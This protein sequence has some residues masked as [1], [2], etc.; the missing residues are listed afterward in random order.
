MSETS[1]VREDSQIGRILLRNELVTPEQL[2]E[3]AE[4][5]KRVKEVGGAILLGEVLIQKG[6]IDESTLTGALAVQREKLAQAFAP[7]PLRGK[8]L[9]PEADNSIGKIALQ[10]GLIVQE[11]L[12]EALAIQEK[13]RALGVE[14][15]LGEIL[16]DR[17]H[18]SHEAL[19]GLLRVQARRKKRA[20][21]A[22]LAA[23]GVQPGPTAEERAIDGVPEPFLLSILRETGAIPPAILEECRQLQRKLSSMSVSKGIGAILLSKGYMSTDVARRIVAQHATQKGA[24]APPASE[25]GFRLQVRDVVMGAA[26]LAIAAYVVFR[27]RPSPAPTGPGVAPPA[28]TVAGQPAPT[29]AA[30]VARVGG[31]SQ[32]AVEPISTEDLDGL[33]V[34][35]L[36]ESALAA[37]GALAEVHAMMRSTTKGSAFGD[38]S[39]FRRDE[40]FKWFAAWE[41]RVQ[42]IPGRGD[43]TLRS[44]LAT[45]RHADSLSQV[46]EAVRV[47][48]AYGLALRS[49]AASRMRFTAPPGP[50]DNPESLHDKAIVLLE[51]IAEAVGFELPEEETDGE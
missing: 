38:G 12:D 18:M 41:A 37:S 28:P 50:S 8:G 42:A 16:V 35:F 39:D 40:F 26:I 17:G 19:E 23:I 49:D 2:R 9:T 4:L 31:A 44:R 47:V 45:T 25:G 24:A 1:R 30:P 13:V 48:H 3:C 43:Q 36:H 32:P 11:Q 14:K 22:E 33:C 27:D 6:F 34:E 21:E 7:H 5:Q 20:T 46:E 29:V 51:A 10:N 15:R